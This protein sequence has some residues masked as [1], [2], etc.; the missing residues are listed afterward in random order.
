MQN[1]LEIDDV[2][3][4]PKGVCYPKTQT[5]KRM[6]PFDSYHELS[7]YLPWFFLLIGLLLFVGILILMSKA[8]GDKYVGY[9]FPIPPWMFWCGSFVLPNAGRIVDEKLPIASKSDSH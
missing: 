6:R 8:E 9:T 2:W 7:T 5:V 4:I 1:Y 3:E